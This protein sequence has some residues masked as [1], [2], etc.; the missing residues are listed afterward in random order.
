M[1]GL[2]LGVAVALV[3]FLLLNLIY[4]NDSCTFLVITSLLNAL[5]VSHF[6]LK[7]QLN[8]CNIMGMG[9]GLRLTLTLLNNV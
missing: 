2:G 8:K 9:S 1:K 4:S 5:V 3:I 7:C 6:R